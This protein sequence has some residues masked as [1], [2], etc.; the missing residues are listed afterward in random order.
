MIIDRR[1]TEEKDNIVKCREPYTFRVKN[2]NVWK[3]RPKLINFECVKVKN[4]RP[5]V[6][7]LESMDA[8]MLVALS[9]KPSN[10]VC[11]FYETKNF[12]ELDRILIK[13]HHFDCAMI[14]NRT[15]PQTDS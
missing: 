11:I 8:V 3:D 7:Y 2:C 9:E 10:I 4:F 5:S 14:V 12:Y 13:R 1:L 15:P 6:H